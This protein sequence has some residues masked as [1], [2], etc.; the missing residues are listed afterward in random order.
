[1]NEYLIRFA[2]RAC[3]EPFFFGHALQVYAETY[4]LDDAGL[5]E[6]LGL[7]SERLLQLKLCRAP[8]TDP[9]GFRADTRRLAEVF[10]VG[11][12]LLA[13]VAREGGVTAEL[14][15]ETDE[16]PAADWALAARDRPP[17]SEGGEPP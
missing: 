11:Q 13:R 10:G 15:T 1:M 6:L 16:S 9:E 2:E 14:R 5:G 8:R 7:D 4:G 12:P 3:R 17:A